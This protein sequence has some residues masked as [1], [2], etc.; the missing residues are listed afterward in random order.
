VGE[1]KGRSRNDRHKTLKVSL[2]DIYLYPLLKRFREALGHETWNILAVYEASPH[3]AVKLL[4]NL[5][6]TITELQGAGCW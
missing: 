1:S 5:M 6:G 3:E 2:K 4:N